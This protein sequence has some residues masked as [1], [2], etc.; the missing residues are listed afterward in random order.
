M[1]R[2]LVDRLFGGSSAVAM[3]NLLDSSD[4]DESELQE[5]RK[6]VQQTKAD[7]RSDNKTRGDK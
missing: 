3:M 6:K 5:L 2:D 1:L 7:T 4:L